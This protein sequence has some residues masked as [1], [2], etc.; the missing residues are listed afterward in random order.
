MHL[1]LSICQCIYQMHLSFT[2]QKQFIIE[3]TS[4]QSHRVNQ[5][6][7]TTKIG[8]KAEKRRNALRNSTCQASSCDFVFGIEVAPT[9]S[10]SIYIHN[11]IFKDVCCITIS[12]SLSVTCKHKLSELQKAA[13][14]N[15]SYPLLVQFEERVS[16]FRGR[17]GQSEAMQ[18]EIGQNKLQQ[19]LGRKAAWRGVARCGGNGLLQDRT[20]QG[21]QLQENSRDQ[22]IN[23]W[24]RHNVDL[25]RSYH[26]FIFIFF[27]S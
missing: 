11:I 13:Q 12:S 10:L 17:G 23:E 26:I 1:H 4:S 16:D 14:H 18:V 7:Q 21:L 9:L 5:D 24:K 19:S 22:S 2:L 27:F 6:H 3:S 15:I 20:S 25:K 8:S